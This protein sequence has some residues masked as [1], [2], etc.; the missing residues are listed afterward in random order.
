VALANGKVEALDSMEFMRAMGCWYQRT[1]QL[2]MEYVQCIMS[3]VPDDEGK[4]ILGDPVKQSL[5]QKLRESKEEDKLA[6]AY[7]GDQFG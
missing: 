6:L 7:A 3:S 4:A 1:V 5:G 2:S